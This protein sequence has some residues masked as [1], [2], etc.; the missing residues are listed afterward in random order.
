MGFFNNYQNGPGI[1][2]YAPKKKGLALFFDLFFR[3]I[4][5]ITGLNVLFFI[6]CLP[7]YIGFFLISFMTNYELLLALLIILGLIFAVTIGP[8]IAGMTKVMRMFLIEKHTYIVRDFFRGFRENFKKASIVGVLDILVA[9]SAYASYN[10]YPYCA[11]KYESKLFY[12]PMILALSVAIVAF[13]MNYYI[14]LMMTATDLSLKNILKNS[15][16]L[17]FVSMKENILT[18][19]FVFAFAF[20]MF[21][22]FINAMPLCLMLVIVFPMALVWFIV[23]F[24]SYPVIQKYVINPYYESMGQDNPE[25]SS[26]VEAVDEETLFEDMGGKEQPIAKRKKGKGKRIS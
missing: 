13:V 8:A 14:F 6:F 22:I 2:K 25:L 5:N 26:E 20:I 12:I 4:W 7:L 15:F 19:I 23:C 18:T 9:L 11:I 1:P 10:V 17:A 16:A 24:I 3:K 21:M